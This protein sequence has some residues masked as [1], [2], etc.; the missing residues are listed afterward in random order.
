MK[1]ATK[2]LGVGESPHQGNRN[3]AAQQQQNSISSATL[4]NSN[5]RNICFWCGSFRAMNSSSF[6]NMP[7]QQ[8][9]LDYESPK[10]KT[11]RENLLNEIHAVT[12]KMPANSSSFL[13]RKIILVKLSTT[14]SPLTMGATVCL[15]PSKATQ[16]I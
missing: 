9:S 1:R 10:S 15:Y 13:A 7:T 16:L 6:N 2:R 14:L 8:P 11:T 4:E 5:K 3:K 12:L